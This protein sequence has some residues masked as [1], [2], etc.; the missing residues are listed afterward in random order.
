M[1]WKRFDRKKLWP[2]SDPVLAFAWRDRGKLE[3]P[4][5]VCH[6]AQDLN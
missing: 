5:D 6:P 1:N 3:G 4:Q 2:T